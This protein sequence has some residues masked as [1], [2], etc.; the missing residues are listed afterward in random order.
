MDRFNIR[1]IITVLLVLL[2]YLLSTTN[3]QLISL[4][5]KS[6]AL[7]TWTQN[8]ETNFQFGRLDNVTFTPDGKLKLKS[9]TNFFIKDT[10]VNKNNI[11]FSENLIFDNELEIVKLNIINKTFGGKYID[12]PG[13]IIKTIDGGYLIVG[14]KYV[15]GGRETSEESQRANNEMAWLIKT[16]STGKVEWDR[17]FGGDN[18]DW[19]SSVKRTSDGG[20]IIAG[21]T[22]TYGHG[23]Y[24]DAWLIK[25]DS[26]GREKWNKTYGEFYSDSAG[27]VIQTSDNGFIFIGTTDNF[28]AGKADFWLL[29][30]DSLGNEQW[31]KTYGGLDDE[32]GYSFKQT[33][34]GG[35]IITGIT[36]SYGKGNAD[37]WLIKTD[38]NGNMSWNKTFGGPNWDQCSTVIETLEERYVIVGEIN[39]DLWLINIDNNGNEIW[40]KTYGEQFLEVGYSIIQMK[41]NG[42]FVVGF[43]EQGG[44]FLQDIWLLKL[45]QTGKIVWEKTFGGD[46]ID[47]GKLIIQSD[48]NGIII[49]G[50]TASYGAGDYDI[51]LL[52]TDY[53]GNDKPIGKLYSNNILKDENVSSIEKFHIKCSL[54]NGTKIKAQFSQDNST[55]YDS[56]GEIN[57]W[58]N[59]TNGIN[60]I[61]LKKLSWK[62]SNFYYKVYFQTDNNNLPELFEIKISYS[63]FKNNGTYQST[64]YNS[65]G[66]SNWKVLNWT[67]NEPDGT[68]IKFRLRTAN[69]DVK[70]LTKPFIG[71]NGKSS[72]YYE[73]SGT[74][75]WSGHTNDKWIQ[76][77]AYLSTENRSVSPILKKV[78]IN[79]NLLPEAMLVNPINGSTVFNNTLVFTWNFSDQDSIKQ[80]AFQLLISDNLSFQNIIIDSNIQNSSTQHWQIVDKDK[81]NKLTDGIWYWKVRTK[82]SNGDWGFYSSTFKFVIYTNKP[83]SNI[84]F[85]INNGIYADID[86][87]S[88]TASVLTNGSGLSRVEISIEQVKDNH[89]W[90]GNNWNSNEFW[91][92]VNGTVSWL[93]DSSNVKWRTDNYYIIRSKAIDNTSVIETPGFGIIFMFDDQPP[94]NL[95]IIINNKTNETN[96]TSVKLSLNAV[97]SGSGIFQMT[98]SSDNFTW[99][100]WENYSISKNYTLTSGN[101]IKPVFFKVKDKAG[102]IADPVYSSILLNKSLLLSD[103]DNDGIL[104]SYDAFPYDPSASVDSDHDNYPDFWNPGKSEKDSTTGLELDAYPNDPERYS[105]DSATGFRF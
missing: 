13:D 93:Y 14:S 46:K 55:W 39:N 103:S 10:F 78:S 77:K 85:P 12:S 69:T 37:I 16:D 80:S 49:S 73:T 45:N 75:I 18:V 61:D 96:S 84:T 91:L 71:P 95:S 44:A 43:K 20:F 41:D 89:F 2:F 66:K 101:G 79:Y 70:L 7:S 33:S 60:F 56:K 22:G 6:E 63:K 31:N 105:K 50:I 47:R 87:I 35:Y 3:N 51:W 17:F 57:G 27:E 98:L 81:S 88:G 58:N 38:E 48:D 15:I 42:F 9:N 11:S 104:D 25:T 54:P 30:T 40:N 26:K 99:G 83:T 62:G 34:D 86:I 64:T 5:K 32:V 94:T 1:K 4:S 100:A 8:N 72:T 65:T 53:K 19:A 36:W 82:D 23:G 28:G 97:D 67:S 24:G 59:L 29:K 74:Q 90:N 92:G 76:Y 52:R 68:D 21:R 102:N